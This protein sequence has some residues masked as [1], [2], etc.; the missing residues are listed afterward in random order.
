MNSIR[1]IACLALVATCLLGASRADAAFIVDCTFGAGGGDILDRGFY[2]SNY[3]GTSIDKVAIAH[4]S[5]VS[6]ER[7]ISLTLRLDSYN[8]TFLSVASV[9]RTIGTIASLSVF[10]FGHIPVAS[11]S[12][13]T[14]SQAVIAGNSSVTYNVGVA[15]C[16]G[17]TQT[18]DTAPPLSSVRRT[19]VGLL[20]EGD[21][22][23]TDFD[24]ALNLVCPY[25]PNGGGDLVNRGFYVTDYRG[26]TIDKVRV[27]HSANAPGNKSLQLVA[28]LNRY[29]GPIVGVAS[30]SRNITETN[31]ESV[32]DFN[33]TPVPAGST[34]TFTEALT[35][36]TGDV[37][38]NLSYEDCGNVVQTFGTTP[39]LDSFYR[40]RVG[41]KISGAVSLGLVEIVEYFHTVFGHYFMTAD[42]DEIAGL[43]GGAYGG[44]FVRTGRELFAYDGP[45]PNTADVCR[46]FTTPGTF[47]AKSSH[48]YTGDAAECA[49]LKANPN[50][51]YE[52]IAFFIAVPAA[53]TCPIFTTPIYRMYNDGM[54]GAPNHRFVTSL[55][56]YNDFTTNQGWT[57][58]GVRFCGPFLIAE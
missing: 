21:P 22:K 49:G 20:I 39:P 43:D 2:V 1:E 18:E 47:G 12:R 58:E 50:W 4:H 9:T 5:S 51:I 16:T 28:R 55:S 37:F 44:V 40:A 35:A 24:N 8:G 45:L 32:Y 19:T 38:R 52:K 36:G 29:D 30:V 27:R 42:P 11:G 23:S 10:D 3:P 7:T 48:F 25:D 13:I 57:G 26:A 56:I 6:G 17:I 33:D 53:G 31:S 15:P 14:F 54:T 41:L 34:I 46:F